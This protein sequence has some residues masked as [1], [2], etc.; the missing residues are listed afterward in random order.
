MAHK[1]PGKAYREG[2][3]LV[4]AMR[5]FPNDEAAEAWFMRVRWPNGP[6]CPACGS[7]NVQMGASHRMALR[8]RERQCRKRFS[9]RY[10]TVMQSSKLG[11]Q[12]WAMAIYL[13]LTSLKSV[14]SMKLH[15]D[16]DI[17]QKSAWHLAH[18]LRKAFDGGGGIFAGPVEMDETYFGGKRANMSKSKREQLTGRGAV[19]KTA[20]VGAKDR[21][22]KQVAAKV[23]ERTDKANI[24]SFVADRVSPDAMV[25]SDDALVYE[26][27]PNPHEVVNHSALEYVRGDVHTNG[28]ESF[29]S[30]LKRAHKG[31]F[32]KMSPKHLN[33]YVQ[34]FAGKHNLRDLDT[35]DIMGAVVL[36]MD[37]KSLKYDELIAPNGLDSGA[38]T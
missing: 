26:T 30:M 1:A 14:S 22:T 11:Y 29:W 9:V 33:R 32:H 23:V 38:R 36:G 21:A 6:A 15:R 31:T 25:Y 8:C 17:T 4:Q 10:G 35:L 27:L 24:H 2:M 28:A 37:G 18:R 20:V 34:E 19:G 16:L 7:F 3:S 13:S 12:V 5:M